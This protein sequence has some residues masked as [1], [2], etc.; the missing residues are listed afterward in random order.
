M[1]VTFILRKASGY[2][3]RAYPAT[4][5]AV[6][7]LANRSDDRFFG[8]MRLANM[9]RFG[10]LRCEK[11]V[12]MRIASIVRQ[13][14]L[15]HDHR[16]M[17]TIAIKRRKFSARQSLLIDSA[18]SVTRTDFAQLFEV[19]AYRGHVTQ[20]VVGHQRPVWLEADQGKK[21]FAMLRG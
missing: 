4:L 21:K 13:S 18:L 1:F 2:P 12:R 15:A 19:P 9:V 17:A 14:L 8:L 11:T 10:S 3:A 7:S 20:M 5:E 16:A 6:F